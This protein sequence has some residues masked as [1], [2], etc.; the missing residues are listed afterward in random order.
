VHRERKAHYGDHAVTCRTRSLSYVM[1]LLAAGGLLLMHGLDV[2]G[3]AGMGEHHPE[4]EAIV[5]PLHQ[6]ADET[7]SAPTAGQ[8]ARPHGAADH[9]G[10]AHVMSLCVAMLAIAGTLALRRL[11]SSSTTRPAVTTRSIGVCARRP[12]GL[13]HPPGPGRLALCIQRI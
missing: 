7:I 6:A 5:L 10:L 8:D 2:G 13:L 12:V 11:S 1:L 9:G 3:H 4:Q